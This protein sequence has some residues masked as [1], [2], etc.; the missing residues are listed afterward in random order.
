L[1]LLL[2]AH[3]AGAVLLFTSYFYL[4]RIFKS[5]TAFTALSEKTDKSAN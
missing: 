4:F 3:A 2:G 1:Q 5:K